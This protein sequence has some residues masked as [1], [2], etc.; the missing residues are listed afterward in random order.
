[1]V[2]GED[3]F[4]IRAGRQNFSIKPRVLTRARSCLILDLMYAG[5][6]VIISELMVDWV[7]RFFPAW[8]LP[9]YVMRGEM[10]FDMFLNRKYRVSMDGNVHSVQED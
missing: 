3:L 2:H 4:T 10:S 9:D 5:G 8:N 7:R 1:M 6:C